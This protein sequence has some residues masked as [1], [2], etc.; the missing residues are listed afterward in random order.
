MADRIYPARYVRL[1][2]SEGLYMAFDIRPYHKHWCTLDSS[3]GGRQR[4]RT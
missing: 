2:A 4:T 3:G 1:L